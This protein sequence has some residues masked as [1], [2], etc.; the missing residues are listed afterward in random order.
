MSFGMIVLSAF[1][2]CASALSTCLC[3]V[4]SAMS[5]A[6]VATCTGLYVSCSCE[7]RASTNR[8]GLSTEPCI[9]PV[10]GYCVCERCVRCLTW[11]VRV[12]K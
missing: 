2:R 1:C 10:E 6:Y 7:L 9:S 12:V 5:S 4:Q 8:T 11:N 3:V